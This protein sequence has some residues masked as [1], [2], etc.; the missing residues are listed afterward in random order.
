MRH[1][2]KHAELVEKGLADLTAGLHIGT[3]RERCQV[4]FAFLDVW[5]S[6]ERGRIFR[7]KAV[8]ART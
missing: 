7:A 3:F 1:V 5:V 8:D 6:V 4:G 2:R